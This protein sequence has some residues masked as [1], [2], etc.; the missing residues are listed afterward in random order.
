MVNGDRLKR[1]RFPD[2]AIRC[3][4][5]AMCFPGSQGG[6]EVHTP[7]F[8]RIALAIAA[9]AAALLLN[10][11]ISAS[12]QRGRKN[13]LKIWLKQANVA[14][15]ADDLE[16]ALDLAAG[17]AGIKRRVVYLQP[18]RPFLRFL[19]GGMAQEAVQALLEEVEI[20]LTGKLTY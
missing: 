8:A 19:R 12:S 13:F 1:I 20:G 14:Y 9:L 17:M 10:T 18:R 5:P 6:Q 4:D 16:A 2:A 15:Q 3:P 11:Q 7:R